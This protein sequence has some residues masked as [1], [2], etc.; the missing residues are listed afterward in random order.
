VKLSCAVCYAAEALAYLAAHGEGRLV[1]SHE[2]ARARGV[3]ERFLLKILRQLGRADL[4]HGVKGPHGGYHL[5]RPVGRISLLE[6]VEAVDGPILTDVAE[7]GSGQALNRQLQAAW[8]QATQA[9]RRVLA[10]VSL[11]DLA[12]GNRKTH[13]RDRS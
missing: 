8:S 2:A 12:G 13:G 5:A 3:P 4:V 7:V 11:A 9:A 6:V 1:P 10:G